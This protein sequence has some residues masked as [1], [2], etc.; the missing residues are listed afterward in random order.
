MNEELKGAFNLV[1]AR[2]AIHF[3]MII[4][5]IIGFTNLI[6]YT[7]LFFVTNFR[8]ILLIASVNV[9]LIICFFTLLPGYFKLKAKESE[10]YAKLKYNLI[11]NQ[12]NVPLERTKKEKKND[13]LSK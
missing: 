1:L 4:L 7:Q 5:A 12:L 10:T 3:Q 8:Q 9:L 11:N 6:I 13:R 2:Q